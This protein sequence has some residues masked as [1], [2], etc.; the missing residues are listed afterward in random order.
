MNKYI[1]FIEYNQK[2]FKYTYF[3]L[4]YNDNENELEQLN[5]ILIRAKYD[6]ICGTHSEF[7]PMN[8][9]YI[10]NEDILYNNFNMSNLTICTGK[11]T[12]PHIIYSDNNMIGNLLNKYFYDGKI[13]KYFLSK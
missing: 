6:T 7:I 11:L 1:E 8:M 9:N 3:Y 12:L 2:T 13:G 5:N 10:I 4:Q